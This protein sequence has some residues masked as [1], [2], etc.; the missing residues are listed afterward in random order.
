MGCSL[1]GEFCALRSNL[2]CRSNLMILSYFFW[3]QIV[4]VSLCVFTSFQWIV[5]FSLEA[6]P[7][8]TT[9]SN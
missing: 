1:S 9:S 5:L 3:C 4:F 8:R 6:S 2:Q 7:H